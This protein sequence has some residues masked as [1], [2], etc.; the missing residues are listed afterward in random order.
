[1]Q[2]AF[3]K[4]LDLVMDG[5]ESRILIGSFLQQHDSPHNIAVI[6]DLPVDAVECIAHLPET[7]LGAHSHRGNIANANRSSTLRLDHDVFDVM[8]VTNQ[9]T[10]AHIDL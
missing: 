2:D 5:G 10:L 9:P 1:G 6:D 8:K 7:N 4:F 3:V